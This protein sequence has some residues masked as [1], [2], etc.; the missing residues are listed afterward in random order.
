MSELLNIGGQETNCHKHP[1]VKLYQMIFPDG[2]MTVYKICF[3]CYNIQE[4]KVIF[5]KHT[6]KIPNLWPKDLFKYLT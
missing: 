6:G 5:E 4:R 1:K 2:T 3:I